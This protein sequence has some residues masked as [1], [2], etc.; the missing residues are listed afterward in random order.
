[1]SPIETIEAEYARRG[2]DF[3]MY[4]EIHQR[5]GFVFSTPEY[6]IMGRAVR[7]NAAPELIRDP[8]YFWVRDS[9]VDP[10]DAWWVHAMAGDPSKCWPLMPWPLGF[11]GFERFDNDLRWYPVERIHQFFDVLAKTA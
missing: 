9:V 6:F 5:R 7:R 10:P 11:I 4:L 1:M 8:R 2:L 3:R